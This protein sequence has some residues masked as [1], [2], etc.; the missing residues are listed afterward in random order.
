ML[1]PYFIWDVII[2]PCHNLN[3]R[4]TISIKVMAWIRNYMAFKGADLEGAHW[5]CHHPACHPPPPPPPPPLPPKIY[6]IGFFYYNINYIYNPTTPTPLCAPPPSFKSWIHP[7]HC[8]RRYIPQNLCWWYCPTS[9]SMCYWKYF[10][11]NWSQLS[12][13]LQCRSMSMNVM[14]SRI[15]DTVCSTA[16]SGQQ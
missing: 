12:D 11:H 9:A 5:A 2:H 6:Q 4:F 10:T 13:S 8:F 1:L 14:V 3:G 7:W 15:A 16:C